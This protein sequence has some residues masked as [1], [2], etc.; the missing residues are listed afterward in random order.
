ML[1]YSPSLVGLQVA[2]E[3]PDHI[4]FARCGYFGDRFL[5]Q[6][7]S[8]IDLTGINCLAHTPYIM[9]LTDRDEPYLAR[10]T[11]GFFALRVNP[12]ANIVQPRCEICH[13]LTGEPWL[14]SAQH[15]G[16]IAPAKY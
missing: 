1:G 9:A 6:V 5:D 2:D 7:L 14:Y 12:A 16:A 8:E 4:I 10:I 3:V 13:I 15:Q 11:T